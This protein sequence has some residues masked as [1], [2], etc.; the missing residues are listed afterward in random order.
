PRC[1][2]THRS[3]ASA[4]VVGTPAASP[5]T[6]QS[7]THESVG[8]SSSVST[9]ARDTVSTRGQCTVVCT[10]SDPNLSV[11]SATTTP[12]RLHHP[13]VKGK[14]DRATRRC[15]LCMTVPG[16]ASDTCRMGQTG[17]VLPFPHAPDGIEL[18]HLRAFVAVAEELNFGRAAE[19]LYVSQPA[20]SRQIR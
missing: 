8:D 13:R 12:A 14:S 20:L 17:S 15:T 16:R 3:A 1:S 10:R 18:R 6:T 2:D 4:L 7:S 19:R 11:M 5:T 9:T